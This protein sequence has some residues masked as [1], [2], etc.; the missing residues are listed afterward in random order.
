M[1]LDEID[2]EA[3]PIAGRQSDVVL[4]APILHERLQRPAAHRKEPIPRSNPAIELGG[5]VEL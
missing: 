4:P 5:Q 2:A 3:L 1:V